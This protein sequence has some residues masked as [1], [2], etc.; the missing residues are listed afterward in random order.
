MRK[1]DIALLVSFEV[2]LYERG[3]YADE[4]ASLGAELCRRGLGNQVEDIWVTYMA[5]REGLLEVGC[6]F[7][8][9]MIC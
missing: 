5:E 9:E 8:R 6:E 7:D 4:V 1:S 3:S 2:A